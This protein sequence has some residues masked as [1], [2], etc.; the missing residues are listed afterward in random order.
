MFKHI[1]KDRDGILELLLRRGASFHGFSKH[2]ADL[3]QRTD[4]VHDLQMKSMC[5]CSVRWNIFS[6]KNPNYLYHLLE[7][8]CRIS[9]CKIFLVMPVRRQFVPVAKMKGDQPDCPWNN[10]THSSCYFS[11]HISVRIKSL[12]NRRQDSWSS[13]ISY[14][15]LC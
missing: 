4:W 12:N 5:F 6:G 13:L 3:H 1:L 2:K 7:A 11:L 10:E 8:K 15:W 9:L 14:F